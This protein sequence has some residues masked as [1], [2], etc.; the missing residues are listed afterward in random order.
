MPAPSEVS[1]D[2]YDPRM[3]LRGIV[4]ALDTLTRGEACYFHTDGT[5]RSCDNGKSDLFHG[6]ALK[7]Y[8]AGTMATLITHGRLNV[9]TAQTI[10]GEALVP[11]TSGGG[12]PDTAGGGSAVAGWAYAT[13][14]IFIHVGRGT[15]T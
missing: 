13:Y 2:M 14:A 5:I 9:T 10:A 6:C 8:A 4:D 3:T 1:W 12:P 15:D 7:D 11:N